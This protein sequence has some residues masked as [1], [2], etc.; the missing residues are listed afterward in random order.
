MDPQGTEDFHGESLLKTGSLVL[1]QPHVLGC[2]LAITFLAW[3][4]LLSMALFQMAD[5]GVPEMDDMTA[6]ALVMAPAAWSVSELLMTASMWIVM[7]A[8][9]M[10]PSAIPMILVFADWS[11]KS[12]GSSV[13]TPSF[14]LGYFM[15]WIGFAIAALAAHWLLSYFG[16]LQPEMKVAS[17]IAGGCI[18]VATGV[19]EWSPLKSRCLANCQ[20]PREFI[21]EHWR[22]GLAGALRTGLSHGVYCLGC[23]WALMLL[24]FAVGVMNLVWVAALSLLVLLQKLLPRGEWLARASGLAMF[25]AGV[26]LIV[27]EAG[28]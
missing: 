18:F 6:K 20:N 14:V 2:L 12:N 19:Y 21:A 10:L 9:M 15:V 1:D 13:A 23:C 3:L 25:A 22:P 17:G 7:M 28:F 27:A 8:S 24:L 5:L 26:Y 16:M 11:G 4:Y